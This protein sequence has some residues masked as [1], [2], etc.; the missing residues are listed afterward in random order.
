MSVNIYDKTTKQ[1]TPIAG[2]SVS[3]GG[4]NTSNFIGTLEEWEALTDAQK[5]QYDTYDFTNDYNGN[6]VDSA[7]SSTS[8]N[9]VQNKVIKEAID[10]LTS[11]NQTLSNK[12]TDNINICGAKNLWANSLALMVAGN[13]YG[14][15]SGNTYQ[16]RGITYTV[17]N[18]GS[19]S[20][21]GTASGGDSQF[22]LPNNKYITNEYVGYLVNGIS[23]GSSSTYYLTIQYSNDGQAWQTEKN[24][25]S[26]DYI[27]EN[28]NYI[29]FSII[30]KND[31][32]VSSKIIK[33][34]VRLASDS[35]GT[36]VPYAMTNRELTI[37][38]SK[39][40][41]VT[42]TTDSD[43]MAVTSFRED[44]VISVMVNV[45]GSNY[46]A[47]CRPTSNGYA[48]V[49]VFNNLLTPVAN[50]TLEIVVWHR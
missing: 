9:P 28:Y 10:E 23:D 31:A 13:P 18:D 3:G 27:I 44:D 32:T 22:F 4:G 11:E 17:N 45:A 24:L 30:V 12:V 2:H 37:L 41:I 6:G 19:I 15:W 39:R 14:T 8:E 25:Y 36:Y 35:D 21:S 20:F 50:R 1:L 49:F 42:V 33:L 26:A 7:L 16:F 46:Y 38:A 40:S 5:A 43:G 34:M 48:D 29:R 47:L